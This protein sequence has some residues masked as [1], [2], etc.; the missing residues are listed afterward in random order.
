MAGTIVPPG[1]TANLKSV[2]N[3]TA[4]G[5]GCPAPGIGWARQV[6]G[7]GS[8]AKNN[9]FSAVNRKWVHISYALI[10]LL[11]ISLSGTVAFAYRFATLSLHSAYLHGNDGVAVSDFAKEHFGFLLLYAILIVLLFQ[12]QDLYRTPRERHASEETWGVVRGVG[13]AT[14]ILAAFIFCANVKIVSREVV[15]ICAV[16]NI[17]LLAGW[18]LWKRSFVIRRVQKGLATRNALIVGAGRVGQ[19]LAQHLEEKKHLGY[20]FSGFLDSNN[21]SNPRLLG[22]IDD[23]PWIARAKFIDEIFITLS[24]DPDLVKRVVGEARLLHLNVK[25]VPEICEGLTSETPIRQ[26]GSLA[27]LELHGET[28]PSFGLFVKRLVDVIL[29]GITLMALSPVFLLLAIATKLDTPGDVFYRAKRI[30]KKGVPFVCYKFRSMIRDAEKRKEELGHLNERDNGLLFK[31]TDDP[32]ITRMGRYLRRYSLDEL[33]QFWNILMGDMSLVGPR[34]P[35]PV[36]FE[37]YSL[38]HL[39][40]LDVKPGLTGLWQV[41]ARRDPSFEQYMNLDLEYIQKWSLL[42]DLKILLMTFPAVIRGEGS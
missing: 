15:G 12:S 4:S 33:P 10:D 26:I 5:Y 18:R 23:L 25:L 30:G 2:P 9:L 22:A 29:S 42:L 14:V 41:T 6:P 32:R 38:D 34:P 20:R 16:L 24:L 37:R 27:V 7:N 31:I 39:R 3:T 13:L 28:I 36:E 35:L 1:Y 40:R 11:L 8:N 19:A 17:A 21:H